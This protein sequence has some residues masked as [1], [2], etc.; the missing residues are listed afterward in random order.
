VAQKLLKTLKLLVDSDEQYAVITT[1]E[2]SA[3]RDL[4]AAI[5]LHYNGQLELKEIQQSKIT[6]ERRVE[7][8][9]APEGFDDEDIR[10]IDIQL[11][12]LVS[13]RVCV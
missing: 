9:N 3:H 4:L 12:M 13:K 5:F 6:E 8:L 10:G 2:P 1:I 7:I 11:V